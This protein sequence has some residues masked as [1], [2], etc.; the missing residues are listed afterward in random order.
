[1]NEDINTNTNDT[2]ESSKLTSYEVAMRDLFAQQIKDISSLIEQDEINTRP[3]I[4]E[5]VFVNVFLP[6]FLNE[7]NIYGV[8]LNHWLYIV[9]KKESRS[10][11]GVWLEVDVVDDNN[12]VLFTVPPIYDRDN[13]SP[14]PISDTHNLNEIMVNAKNLANIKPSLMVK[15]LGI[16]YQTLLNRIQNGS[17]SALK[18]L[19]TWNDIAMRYGRESIF[20]VEK[21]SADKSSVGTLP[22]N[23]Y[24]IDE[25]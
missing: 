3:T 8:N 11:N 20:K 7:N 14:K 19:N 25:L 23:T 4:K 18:H 9:N 12:Q 5:D 15:Q 6:Y 2:T 21:N 24:E 10:H 22:E 1:M 17:E 13:L 16:V